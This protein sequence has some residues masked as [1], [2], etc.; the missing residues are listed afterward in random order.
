MLVILSYYIQFTLLLLFE[1]ILSFSFANIKLQD[2]G[3][4][5]LLLF[6]VL[7]ILQLTVY[8]STNKDILLLLYPYI[9]H[10][11]MIFILMIYFKKHIL[12]SIAATTTAYICCRPAKWVGVFIYYITQNE[13]LQLLASN[14]V[15]ILF[16]LYVLYYVSEY[17]SKLYTKDAHSIF[18]FAIIPLVFYVYDYLLSI[19][20]FDKLTQTTY[21]DEFSPLLLCIVYLLFCTIYYKEHEQKLEIEQKEKLIQFNIEQQTKEI[22]TLQRTEKEMRIIRHDLRLLLSNLS[23]SL[24][25][26]D[27]DNAQKMIDN[28]ITR[29][30]NTVIKRYC[31]N[32][33]IN[34]VI[35]NYASKCQEQGVPFI[36]DIEIGKH[37]PKEMMLSI[38][39]S[40]ALDNALNAQN[41]LLET[42]R[43]IKLTLKIVNNKLLIKIANPFKTAPIMVDGI[44]T[45]KEPGHGYGVQSILATTKE[46]NGNCQ[47]SLD[48]NIFIIRIII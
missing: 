26:N 21:S 9:T 23:I 48:G 12:T 40:N 13:L 37:I 24:Q 1:V 28:Y 11:P 29:I 25:Q 35:Q 14:L 17:L 34:Y 15:Y 18:I 42:Q 30:D 7:G 46:L 27:I 5:A 33:M 20:F 31:E 4:K 3:K 16:G 41:E 43:Y 6:I 2:N 10:I 22:N 44:P 45:N 32:T 39:L 19:S 36:T 38:L 8:Y 47:F